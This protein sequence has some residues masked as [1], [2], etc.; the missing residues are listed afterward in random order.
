MLK[1][2]EQDYNYKEM[3]GTLE[4]I[5]KDI[6]TKLEEMGE[7]IQTS[8]FNK[9]KEEL[10]GMYDWFSELFSNNKDL[11]ILENTNDSLLGK[12]VKIDATDIKAINLPS[13]EKVEGFFAR[14]LNWFTD[15]FRNDK[16]EDSN[17]N[18][19]YNNEILFDENPNFEI[20]E[21]LTTELNEDIEKEEEYNIVE[22]N[23]ISIDNNDDS[24]N[25]DTSDSNTDVLNNE[26]LD[27]SNDNLE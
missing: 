16:V 8:I 26:N 13:S 20:D 2:S 21:S 9:I 6:N 11:G 19:N 14:I 22:D 12:N 3:K 7:S 17:N 5:N 4:N 27:T 18:D 25:I 1:I 15:L 10:S 23:N 24:N